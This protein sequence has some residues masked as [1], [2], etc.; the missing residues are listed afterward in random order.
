MAQVALP[1]ADLA[2]TCHKNELYTHRARVQ[3]YVNNKDH[4]ELASVSSD[5]D[6]FSCKTA[7]YVTSNTSSRIL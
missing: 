3:E 6:K 2:N 1:S 5:L 4:L 7:F